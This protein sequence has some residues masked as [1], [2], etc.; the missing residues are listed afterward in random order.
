MPK[1]VAVRLSPTEWTVVEQEEAP[2]PQQQTP[3]KTAKEVV[4]AYAWWLLH[5]TE[6]DKLQEARSMGMFGGMPGRAPYW[7]VAE[8]GAGEYV[9][10]KHFYGH[11]YIRDT[12][13]EIYH[14]LGHIIV[15]HFLS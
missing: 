1:K 8:V 7:H 3:K 13:T 2:G 11:H 15:S 5:Q 6:K 9:S 12:A 4:S 10:S 14:D